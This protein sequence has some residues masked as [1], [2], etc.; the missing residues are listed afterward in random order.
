[1]PG[2]PCCCSPCCPPQQGIGTFANQQLPGVLHD[3]EVRGLD[4]FCKNLIDEIDCFNRAKQNKATIP[5]ILKANIKRSL[6]KAFPDASEDCIANAVAGMVE[7][8]GEAC[9][10]FGNDPQF[11]NKL[12]TGVAPHLGQLLS[13]LFGPER[14][15][16]IELAIYRN[17]IPLAINW[18]ACLIPILTA[19]CQ[20]KGGGNPGGGGGG[21]CPGCGGGG[22]NSSPF[23]PDAPE[24]D[25]P[26]DRDG[27][28]TQSQ[29]TGGQF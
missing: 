3:D 20:N 21:G 27:I 23:G 11:C 24:H 4:D 26:V 13:C 29:S 12:L 7:A 28:D 15:Q 18:L 10:D 16:A 1:M 22:G 5:N 9:L 14:S 17:A 8:V 25:P 6:V 2:L 19:I